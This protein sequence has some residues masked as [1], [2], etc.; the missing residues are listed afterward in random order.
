M[1][2]SSA[3]LIAR[4]A[5]TYAYPLVLMEV[6][7]RQMTDTGPGPVRAPCNVFSHNKTFPKGGFRTVVRPNF[8]TYYSICWLDLKEEPVVL[9]APASNGRY[10]ILQAL[11][12]YTDVFASI[13]PR[14]TGDQ[15]GDYVFVGPNWIGELP[16]NTVRVD[17]PTSM[18]WIL[19]RTAASGPNDEEARK[20]Q[21][22]YNATLLSRWNKPG[23]FPQIPHK[24]DPSVDFKTAPPKQVEKMS[25]RDFFELAAKLMVDNPPHVND[26]PIMQRLKR[27]GWVAG[28]GFGQ[29]DAKSNAAM[30]SGLADARASIA[31]SLETAGIL[32][33]GW[34]TSLD[35]GTYGADYM[36][37]AATAL[38]G[39]G[40]NLPEDSFY[41]TLWSDADGKP[42]DGKQRYLLRFDAG[43]LPPAGAFWSVTLYDHDGYT[44]ANRLARYALGDRDPLVY[45]PDGSLELLIGGSEPSSKELANWLPAGDDVGFTLLMRVYDPGMEMR[46]G[47]WVPPAV[48]KVEKGVK[49]MM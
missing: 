26:W 16:E 27:A 30:E 48:R 49:V 11:D 15:A 29:L 24:K 19:G 3:R 13:C 36:K 21:A 35:L 28:R 22:G 8:D 1:D 2:A 9:S 14:N 32:A 42:L 4:D 12:A 34:R 37:R 44:V 25:A 31:A 41:P 47:K 20:L 5:Y 45:G 18:V 38:F 33:N 7:R 46:E 17:S 10:Y 40:A 39:I 6:S 43:K 23:P